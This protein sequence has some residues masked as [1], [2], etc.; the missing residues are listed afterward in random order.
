M[1]PDQSLLSKQTPPVTRSNRLVRRFTL[2]LLRHLRD[3]KSWLKVF[4]FLVFVWIFTGISGIIGWRMWWNS[5]IHPS[6]ALYGA[7]AFSSVIAFAIVFSFDFVSGSN[8]SFEFAG[9]KFTGTSGP[10]T[11]WVLVFLSIMFTFILADYK[12]LA[13]STLKPGPALHELDPHPEH[14][15][16]HYCAS[17]ADCRALKIRANKFFLDVP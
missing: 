6:F 2:F 13:R 10:V 3:A 4:V 1:D 8:L 17:P 15:V 16:I 12:S 9:L 11:L 7:V 14:L 5:P